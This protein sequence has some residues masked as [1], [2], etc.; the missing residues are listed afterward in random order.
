M[1]NF[2]SSN[3]QSNSMCVGLA[4]SHY[5]SFST[6]YWKRLRFASY[7]SAQLE[8]KSKFVN[9]YVVMAL[10]NVCLC[11]IAY[12]CVVCIVFCSVVLCIR[13]K[14]CRSID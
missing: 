7:S 8:D 1:Q 11:V 5:R 9:M 2:K 4:L 12:P 14:I 10:R 6:N 3:H 13:V